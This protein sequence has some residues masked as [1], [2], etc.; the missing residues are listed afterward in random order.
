VTGLI[1]GATAT[2]GWVRLPGE[3]AL[4]EP[5]VGALC[6]YLARQPVCTRG[7][8]FNLLCFEALSNA[9]RHGCAGDPTRQV[10]ATLAVALDRLTLT[11]ADD[12]PGFDW[13]AWAR[14]LPGHRQTQGRGLWIL[15]R[16][17][18]AVEFNDA[19]NQVTVT[20]QLGTSDIAR[21]QGR[22]TP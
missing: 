3:L 18:D 14:V 1:Q 13:R 10:L 21:N 11:V 2:G 8:E 6:A 9:V 16:Y 4:V 19:G 22:S 20:K 15:H 5:A 7:L 12:G 17:S